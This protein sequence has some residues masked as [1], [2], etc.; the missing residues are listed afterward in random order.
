M[1]RA[2]ARENLAGMGGVSAA[3]S[4]DQINPVARAN[5]ADDDQGAVRA[6]GQHVIPGWAIVAAMIDSLSCR[7]S[8]LEFRHAIRAQYATSIRCVS[9]GNA[10]V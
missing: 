10:A 6:V 8:Q 3:R 1:R 5:A 2:V 4:R 9:G 7:A